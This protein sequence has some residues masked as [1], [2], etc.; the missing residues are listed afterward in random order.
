MKIVT[1]PFSTEHGVDLNALEKL[2][3]ERKFTPTKDK[4]FWGV[5]YTIPTYHNPTG[6]LYSDEMNKKILEIARE[7]DVL[8]ACDDVYNV[9]SYGSKIPPKRLFAYDSIT[10]AKYQGNVISNGTF[11]KIL[12][13]GIRLGWME[14]PQKLVNMFRDSGVL[15]SGGCANGYMT[16]IVQSLIELK[17]LDG[18]LALYYD[19]YKERM[20]VACTILKQNLDKDCE[21]HI[22]KGGYFIWITFPEG[23]NCLEFNDF[24][25]KNFGVVAIAGPRFSALGLFKNCMRLTIA[26]HEVGILES[27][28]KRFCQA[29]DAYKKIKN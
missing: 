15:K 12:S 24:C 11:S 29:F 14:C 18:H 16:G 10:D 22:P 9:L 21:F 23:T 26:F 17:L 19:R 27:A 25:R 13:P 7:Y 5:Y 2:I 28:I 3:S 4:P 6:V 8:V 1:V 20:E